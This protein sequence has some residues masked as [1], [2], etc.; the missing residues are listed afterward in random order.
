MKRA[1]HR[2]KI[3]NYLI[4][5]NVQMKIAITN[6]A[7]ML[8]VIV[9]VLAAVLSPF[10]SDISRPDDLCNQY[11]SAR[12]FIILLERLFIALFGLL[13]IAFFHQILITHKFCGPLVNIFNSIRQISRGNLTRKIFLRKYDFLQ[14]EAS[15]VNGMMDNL[16]A[17]I[18]VIRQQNDLLLATL[19]NA[20]GNQT[21]PEKLSARLKKAMA[22]ARVCRDQ[23]SQFKLPEKETEK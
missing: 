2:R 7:Y 13:I 3:R 11:F 8:V 20:T 6:L 12:M 21:N 15:Q 9:I 18:T 5:R 10:Y 22:H 19:D 1:Q 16:A 4:M 14:P 23:L 17:M